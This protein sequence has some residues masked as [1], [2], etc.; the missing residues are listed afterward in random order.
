MATTIDA[1]ETQRLLA[2]YETDEHAWATRQAALLRELAPAHPDLP[3]D[4]EH[5]A[6]ELDL[7]ARS[8]QSAC[9]SHARRALQHLLKLEH[10]PSERPRRGWRMSVD[11]ARE[12]LDDL[13][14]PTLRRALRGD[15]SKLHER[16]R[17]SA[18]LELLDHGERDAARALPA[19]C[20][21]SLDQL[22]DP[23][24]FPTNRHGLSDEVP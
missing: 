1:G 18:A 3:I 20:P 4:F 19:E 2:L 5:V 21:Y 7:L 8:L 13:L 14:T 12:S 23:E 24:W 11:D 22:L 9:R 17:R 10:S 6:E 15:L 16:A